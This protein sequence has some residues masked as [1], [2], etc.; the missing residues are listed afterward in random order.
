[1]KYMYEDDFPGNSK[2]ISIGTKFSLLP[3]LKMRLIYL[4]AFSEYQ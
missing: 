3:F 1:M 4:S 2:A